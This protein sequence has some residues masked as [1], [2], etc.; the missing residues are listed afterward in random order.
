[1]GEHDGY[2]R[3]GIWTECQRTDTL[4][5]E[6]PHFHM[7]T[8]NRI[9]HCEPRLRNTETHTQY[10]RFRSSF[11][12]GPGLGIRYNK[13]ESAMGNHDRRGSPWFVAAGVLTAGVMM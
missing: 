12:A 13:E 11:T 8:R 6:V 10:K 7:P 9:D 1:M 3:V 4:L 5:A 2:S